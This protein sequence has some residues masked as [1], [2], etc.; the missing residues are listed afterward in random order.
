[1]I[2]SC[3][4]T[5]LAGVPSVFISMLMENLEKFTQHRTF[6]EHFHWT[7]IGLGQVCFLFTFEERTCCHH[8]HCSWS[9][10][11]IHTMQ[12]ATLRIWT[13]L[14]GSRFP[15]QFSF[16]TKFFSLLSLHSPLCVLSIRLYF[17]IYLA[18]YFLA[19]TLVILHTLFGHL[20]NKWHKLSGNITYRLSSI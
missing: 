2:T 16:I 4:L 7:K 18:M 13:A 15:P 17:S 14:W 5:Y 10:F 12:M 8:W 6:W 20:K 11:C 1:M 19:I 3:F 9:I